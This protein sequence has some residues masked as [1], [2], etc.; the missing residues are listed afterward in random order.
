MGNDAEAGLSTGFAMV[1]TNDAKDDSRSSRARDGHRGKR[2][3]DD[4]VSGKE[5]VVVTRD[6]TR[7]HRRDRDRDRDKD[8]DSDRHRGRHDG[9]DRDSYR[10]RITKRHHRDRD[11]AYNSGDDNGSLENDDY[12]REQRRAARRQRRRTGRT[13]RGEGHGRQ[14]DRDRGA[15]EKESDVSDASASR[16]TPISRGRS[17]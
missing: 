17:S 13:D 11:G 9:P 15:S 3:V 2:R 5:E 10:R 16:L 4:D 12:I 6:R 8:R 14:M 7:R 1:T